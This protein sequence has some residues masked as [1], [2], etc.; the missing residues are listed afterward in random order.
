[1]IN[2]LRLMSL[3]IAVCS[4]A[5]SCKSQ[6]PY[7]L[8]SSTH[9]TDLNNDCILLGT[10]IDEKT[11]K[12]INGAVIEI[13]DSN[14][15]TITDRNGKYFLR[16]NKTGEYDIKVFFIGFKTKTV[17]NY[18]LSDNSINILNFTMVDTTIVIIEY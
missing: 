2:S 10:V 14:F 16:F 8:S 17:Y 7:F 18:P 4:L 1:M 6:K 5:F 15:G 3:L 11:L 9:F 13:I 12:P